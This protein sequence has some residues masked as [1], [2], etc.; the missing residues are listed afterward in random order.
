MSLLID[1]LALARQWNQPGQGEQLVTPGMIPAAPA[2]AQSTPSIPNPFSG[3]VASGSS[4]AVRGAAAAQ[5][6]RIGNEFTLPMDYTD[7][8][9]ILFA[10]D[11]T[12]DVFPY[13]VRGVMVVPAG[14]T[15]QMV[16]T[17]PSDTIATVV[18]K[19]TMN[20]NLYTPDFTVTMQAD[21]LP[22]MLIEVPMTQEIVVLGSF[23]P[24]VKTQGTHTLV[25]STSQ[26]ITFTDDVQLAVMTMEYARQVWNPLMQGQANLLRALANQFVQE[27]IGQ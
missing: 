12:G 16:T 11:K 5:V 13:Y 22:P 25:N 2:S 3:E 21:N 26:D 19:H 24:P 10:S 23:L 7:L 27:G 1:E 18:Y 17:V 20:T 4:P 6:K 8:L 14:M 9:E 15:M